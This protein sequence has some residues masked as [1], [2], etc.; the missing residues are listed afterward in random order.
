[1]NEPLSTPLK[2]RIGWVWQF[3]GQWCMISDHV[4]A[5]AAIARPWA[6]TAW[7]EKAISSPTFHRS[8]G[9]GVSMKTSNLLHGNPGTAQT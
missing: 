2:L 5:D 1:M 8:P 7:P 9:S 4:S 6:S 3:E